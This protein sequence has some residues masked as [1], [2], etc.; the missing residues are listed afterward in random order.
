MCI[1]SLQT[2]YNQCIKTVFWQLAALYAIINFFETG[3]KFLQ[4][5]DNLGLPL[6]LC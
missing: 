3:E 5:Y 1:S 4:H 6:G 2:E